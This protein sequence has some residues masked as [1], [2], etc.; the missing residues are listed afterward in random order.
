MQSFCIKMERAQD[1]L[2]RVLKCVEDSPLRMTR[3]RKRIIETLACLD[4]PVTAPELRLRAELS[5]NDLVTVYRNLES[6]EEIGVI[7]K[8]QLE[9]GGHIFELIEPHDHHHHF[10]CRECHKTSRLD[11]CFDKE[12]KKQAEALGFSDI[13]H[14]MGVYG[15][16]ND[17]HSLTS[18][19][20][21]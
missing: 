21:H 10:V 2:Q 14:V 12:L 8:I 9:N 4:R 17:C 6:L 7:Q 13:S 19:P 16:C 15:V 11:V 3:K 5:E 20:E 18:Q 1:F